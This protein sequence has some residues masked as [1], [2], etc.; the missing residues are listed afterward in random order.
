MNK[1]II[2]SRYLTPAAIN[3]QQ[4]GILLSKYSTILSSI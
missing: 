4:T 3:E 1:C 2:Y